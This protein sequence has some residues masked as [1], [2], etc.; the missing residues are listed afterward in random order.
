MNSMLY[1]LQKSVYAKIAADSTIMALIEGVYDDPPENTD[2]PYI[3][4]GEATSVPW[5]SHDR[6]GEEV[7]F[8]LHIWSQQAG[9]SEGLLILKELNRL[10][11]YVDLVVTGW[12]IVKCEYEFSDTFKDQDGL[13]RHV[14]VRYRVRGL[15][16]L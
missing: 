13:T 7:T 16:N 3:T 2:Y 10:F 5:R 11:G 14:V 8:T 9:F 1:E 12:D 6:P 15:E 4:I